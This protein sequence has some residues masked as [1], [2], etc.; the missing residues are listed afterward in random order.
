MA[1]INLKDS[2]YLYKKLK[3]RL[4]QTHSNLKI[5]IE[6][7]TADNKAAAQ[8]AYVFMSSRTQSS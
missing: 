2:L 5:F 6:V 1:S 7:T 4:K 3:S 8:A